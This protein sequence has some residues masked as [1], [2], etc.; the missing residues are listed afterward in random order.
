M[1]DRQKLEILLANRFPGST[2]EQI[3]AAA[4]AIV[5]MILTAE[6][7]AEDEGSPQ[8]TRAKRAASGLPLQPL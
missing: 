1:V 7:S 3:A 2:R 4:N 5:A 8:K 6:N